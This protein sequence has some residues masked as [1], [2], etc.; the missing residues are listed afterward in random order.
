MNCP[1]FKDINEFDTKTLVAARPAYCREGAAC[2][3]PLLKPQTWLPE[4][5]AYAG[6]VLHHWR[7]AIQLPTAPNYTITKLSNETSPSTN[8]GFPGRFTSTYSVNTPDCVSVPDV[9]KCAWIGMDPKTGNWAPAHTDS[10]NCPGSESQELC[11]LPKID[12]AFDVCSGDQSTIVLGDLVREGS[13][14]AEAAPGVALVSH[15]DTQAFNNSHASPLQMSLADPAQG[16]VWC[17][18]ELKTVEQLNALHRAQDLEP[19]HKSSWVWRGL[20]YFCLQAFGQVVFQRGAPEDLSLAFA[21]LGDLGDSFQLLVRT[22]PDT[23][24][25]GADVQ[26]AHP[27]WPEAAKQL[28]VLPH[29]LD[30]FTVRLTIPPAVLPG[31]EH[32]DFATSSLLS[33]VQNVALSDLAALLEAFLRDTS[34]NQST[35]WTGVAF[36][37]GPRKPAQLLYTK[38]GSHWDTMTMPQTRVEDDLFIGAVVYDLR[39]AKWSPTLVALMMRDQAQ[40]SKTQCDTFLGDQ[41]DIVTVPLQCL[42]SFCA[43]NDQRLRCDVQKACSRAAG[44]STA[45]P[46]L[47]L[48]DI[49]VSPD[50]KLCDC[51]TSSVGLNDE[52]SHYARCFASSCRDQTP[53]VQKQLDLD[54]VSCRGQCA[55]M[56]QALRSEETIVGREAVDVAK[57]QALC[58]VSF[59]KIFGHRR[60]SWAGAGITAVVMLLLLLIAWALAAPPLVLWCLVLASSVS[61]GFMG[62][63]LAGRSSCSAGGQ[64]EC[65]VR[66][67]PEG[68]PLPLSFCD[69]VRCG[70]VDAGDEPRS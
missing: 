68:L 55:P 27:I 56:I 38:D 12:P 9:K 5:E 18:Y 13:C 50:T 39:I 36:D 30:D 20:L 61:I 70:S 65:S 66:F 7:P 32:L 60:F 34:Q 52:G 24:E 33:L 54:D 41:Q 45:L 58:H 43:P 57:L 37:D 16:R 6:A 42:N 64:P 44:V 35:R 26:S 8:V 29:F 46:G 1:V 10:A 4:V 59:D 14:P 23:L 19:R 25:V 67:W 15:W 11:A 51:V 62:Y 48:A 31:A 22:L 21:A 53:N 49:I 28:C 47:N 63:N 2:A 3:W 17:L 69:P 40:C